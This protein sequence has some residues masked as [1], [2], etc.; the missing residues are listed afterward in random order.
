MG[1]ITPESMLDTITGIN[2]VRN[3]LNRIEFGNFA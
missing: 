2:E 1:G 3:C